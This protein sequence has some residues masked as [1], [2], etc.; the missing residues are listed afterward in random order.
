[1]IAVTAGVP[2]RMV[3]VTWYRHR[4]AIAGLLAIF[5]AVSIV[6]IVQGTMM[7]SALSG[8]GLGRC[9][10]S[11]GYSSVCRNS[12]AWYA[13]L[14]RPYYADDIVQSLNL[15][16]YVAAMFAGLPWLT[17]EFET[18]SFRYTWVQGISRTQW[19]L[20]TFA[21]LA[22]TAALAAA[23]CGLAFDWW[24]RVA[25]W[26]TDEFPQAGW[27]WEAFGLAP[28][29]LAGFTVF[30]MALALLAGLLIRRTVPAMAVCAAACVTCFVLVQWQ[31]R[32]WLISLAPVVARSQ[33]GTAGAPSWNGLYLRGWLTGADGRPV[34]NA[35]LARL[36]NLTVPQMDSWLT[37]HHYTFWIAYQPHDRLRLFQFVLAAV[38]L[39]AAA[40]AVL[41]G[42]WLLRTRA[43]D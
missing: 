4:P 38:L 9:L 8:H 27:S 40:G 33:Y 36:P 16:P 22:A 41:T 2:L 11:S 31:L 3:R 25:Q 10:V 23:A 18:G 32:D 39:V 19:L 1:M 43:T 42:A 29:T 12:P 17:R 37:E 13:F 30:A 14:N 7:R 26:T 35:V 6:L 5:A 24:Y 28:E 21:P 34:S 20:G 15:V